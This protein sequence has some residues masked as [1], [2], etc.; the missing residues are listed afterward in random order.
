MAARGRWRSTSI[1]PRRGP[2]MRARRAAAGIPA[3]CGFARSGAS[4]WRRCARFCQAGFT[5]TGVVVDAD[6]GEQRRS[7][8]PAWSGSGLAYG[9]AIRG[10]VTFTVVG[11]PGHAVRHRH[12]GVGPRRRVGDRDVGHR[13]RRPAH[14]RFC[15]LR[16]RPDD[17][18]RRPLVALRT[19]GH[20]RAEVLPAPSAGHDARWSIS[21]RSRAAAGPSNSNIASSKT[22]SAS[23]TSK[24]APIRAGRI[25]SC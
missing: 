17:G 2:T 25:T 3:T 23:I 10:E 7:S 15:A 9:V 19:L 6:Y 11:V 12:R 8:A 5:I 22:T 4:R 14:R 21:S 18:P 16:V 24:A 13:H 20:R 1:C